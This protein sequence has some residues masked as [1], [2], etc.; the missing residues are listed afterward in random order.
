MD[1]NKKKLLILGGVIL[2]IIVLIIADK[3]FKERQNEENELAQNATEEQN[4]NVL[5][6]ELG[7]NAAAD[8]QT[9]EK[10][11]KQ[12]ESDKTDEAEDY[13]ESD[14]T[15]VEDKDET[16]AKQKF[17]YEHWLAAGAVTGISMYYMDF[18]LEGIY[19]ASETPL[20]NHDDSKGV[21]VVFKSGGETLTLQ[22]VPLE[23]ERSYPGTIDLST[24]NFG[25]ATFDIVEVEESELKKCEEVRLESL[26][27]LINQLMLV[28]L[29]EH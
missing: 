24:E 2:A 25:F 14:E 15:K 1:K 12:D 4:E 19:L 27:G 8:G 21:Y 26:S 11:G 7:N 22:S 28:T 3:S 16:T 13:D 5:N 18:E 10:S 20:G 9:D 17:S 23:E 29:Y 6:N